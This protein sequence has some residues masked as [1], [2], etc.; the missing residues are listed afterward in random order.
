VCIHNKDIQANGSACNA[1][2]RLG[3]QNCSLVMMR[4][5]TRERE[6]YVRTALIADGHI[7]RFV[8]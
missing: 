2:R 7:D 5:R 4:I 1:R 3:K 6:M 8:V